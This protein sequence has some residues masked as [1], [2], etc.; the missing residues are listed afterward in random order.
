MLNVR[1]LK[2]L[3]SQLNKDRKIKGVWKMNRS[4]LES[5][6]D[7]QG[8]IIDHTKKQLK[9]KNKVFRQKIVKI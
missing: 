4:Q 7:K 1:D 8:Y 5:E 3:L 2:K 6:I 9:P